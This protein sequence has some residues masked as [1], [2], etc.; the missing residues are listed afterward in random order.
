MSTKTLLEKLKKEHDA[1]EAAR[2][3]IMPLANAAQ[4]ASKRAIFALQRDDAPA[5]ERLLAEA[6]AKFADIAEKMKVNARLASEGA[7]RA[8]LEEYAEA[9][10]VEQLIE[11]GSVSDLRGLDEETQIAGLCDAVGELVRLM[12]IRATE[13]KRREVVKLKKAAET[14]VAGLIAAINA[15]AAPTD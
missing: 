12:T 10:F 2:R 4:H 3:E 9:R 7:Y 15:N 11:N 13:K 8:A 14:A 5:A 6:D 1:Y